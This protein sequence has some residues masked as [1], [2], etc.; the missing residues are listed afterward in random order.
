MKKNNGLNSEGFIKRNADGFT[1]QDFLKLKVHSCPFCETEDVVQWFD[2][3]TKTE[4]FACFNC[5]YVSE[6][7]F[8]EVNWEQ[9]N[10]D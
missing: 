10:E 1:K 9:N 5:D 6:E 8:V 2:E 3:K 7:R 4:H